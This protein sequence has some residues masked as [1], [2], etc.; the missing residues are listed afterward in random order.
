MMMTSPVNLG[1]CGRFRSLSRDPLVVEVQY[2]PTYPQQLST[3][4][5]GTR[6][7]FYQV[8]GPFCPR[9]LLYHRTY[10]RPDKQYRIISPRNQKMNCT[11]QSEYATAF[12]FFK[13]LK[14]LY[15]YELN[16]VSIILF[17]WDISSQLSYD[18][19]SIE[20]R[21]YS[22]LYYYLLKVIL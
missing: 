15:N 10:P 14:K 16:I 6:G 21:L 5:E 9:V 13:D 22:L 11:L 18:S 20:T 1:G 3:K 8:G 17:F 19:E 7:G 12:H 2:R 4:R